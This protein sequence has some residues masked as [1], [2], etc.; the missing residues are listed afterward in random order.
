WILTG[1]H[2]DEGETIVQ[3]GTLLVDGSIGAVTVEAGATLGGSGTTGPVT[4]SPG[5]SLDPGGP[6]PGIQRV[7]DLAFSPSAS[8][9]VQLDGPDPGSG[10][11]QLDVTGTVS[12]DDATL[13]ASL[14]FSPEAGQRFVIINNDGTDPVSGTFG[15]LPQGAVVQIGGVPFHVYYDGGD[16]ND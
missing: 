4:L 16:G 13:N 3:G 12:L 15:G 10:Y 9:V 8:Y 11:D 6:Q 1:V 2:T 14:G 5:A 7:R